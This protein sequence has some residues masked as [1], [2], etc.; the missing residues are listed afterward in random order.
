MLWTLQLPIYFKGI[1]C[2][3]ENKVFTHIWLIAHIVLQHQQS[4]LRANNNKF[5]NLSYRLN[6]IEARIIK[7]KGAAELYDDVVFKPKDVI[8]LDV[9]LQQLFLFC[10]VV[11]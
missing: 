6:F 10:K 2:I 8:G 9:Q 7:I 5:G 11:E 3:D 4:R 1:G